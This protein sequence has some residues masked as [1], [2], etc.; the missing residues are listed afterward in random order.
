MVWLTQ[1][2]GAWPQALGATV[3]AWEESRGEAGGG[4]D[5]DAGGQSG[6][7]EEGILRSEQ[8]LLGYAVSLLQAVTTSDTLGHREHEWDRDGP[9][10]MPSRG[11][12]IG[13]VLSD[14]GVHANLTASLQACGI[15]GVVPL[16]SSFFLDS[17]VVSIL[18]WRGGD[19]G[20]SDGWCPVS[21]WGARCALEALKVLTNVARIDLALLQRMIGSVA[22][23]VEF[24]HLALQV[25]RICGGAAARD[26]RVGAGGG[27][28]GVDWCVVGDPPPANSSAGRAM[29]R[30]LDEMVLLLGYLATPTAVGGA[31]SVLGGWRNVGMVIRALCELDVSYFI[32]PARREVLLPSLVTATLYNAELLPVMEESV[33]CQLVQQYLESYLAAHANAGVISTATVS[34]EGGVGLLRHWH[35]LPPVGVPSRFHL[36]MRLGF[37]GWG[38]AVAFYT[39]A[40]E[41]RAV[42]RQVTAGLDMAQLA[43]GVPVVDA[44]EGEEEEGDDERGEASGKIPTIRLSEAEVLSL[45]QSLSSCASGHEG[46]S[47]GGG[48]LSSARSA[49]GLS[50]GHEGVLSGAGGADEVMST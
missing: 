24:S 13:G 9:R 28:L 6:R 27:A 3:I 47:G 50:S 41:R 43:A 17:R 29:T 32:S 42:L 38:K 7:H 35:S 26:K 22:V 10:D 12:I 23:Q 30:I 45:S 39:E 33:S 14:E 21:R 36:S 2:Y 25:L 48:G 19:D 8:R 31:S 4:H 15:G 16:L 40:Q 18:R 44:Q 5:R 34:G 20:T 49:R 37:E 11:R 46:V 1:A